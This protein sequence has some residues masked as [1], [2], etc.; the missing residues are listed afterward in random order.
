MKGRG[1]HHQP[2]RLAA[3][4]AAANLRGW[5]CEGAT[6]NER[7]GARGKAAACRV[8]MDGVLRRKEPSSE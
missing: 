6:N 2:G 1:G 5:W 4:R 8:E 7:D 3:R